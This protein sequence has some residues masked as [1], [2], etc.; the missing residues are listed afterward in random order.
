MSLQV[1][2]NKTTINRMFA[3]VMDGNIIVDMYDESNHKIAEA[4]IQDFN[5]KKI[6][7]RKILIAET[8]KE[9]TKKSSS[10]R[11]VIITKNGLIHYSTTYEQKKDMLA[12]NFPKSI[13]MIQRRDAFR[14]T[15]SG[16]VAVI[17]MDNKTLSGFIDDISIT[18]LRIVFKNDISNIIKSEMVFID[19]LIK[20]DERLNFTC[21]V[22]VI[23]TIE[24]DDGIQTILATKFL[25]FSQQQDADLGAFI[26][27]QSRI[28]PES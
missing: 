28:R 4:I 15:I 23:R 1:I 26:A 20:I 5:K 18:G 21:D 19:C 12:L 11:I 13:N 17:E 7:L 24:N 14:A 25:N 2:D 3:Q 27:A 22:E 16:G 10:C 6:N 8:D 9:L